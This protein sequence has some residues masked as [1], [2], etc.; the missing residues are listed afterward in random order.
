M[1]GKWFSGCGTVA[2]IKATYRILAKR[3]HPDCGGD[4]ATMAEINGEYEDTLKSADGEVYRDDQD[5]EHTYHYNAKV[6][7]DL[8]NK[9]AELLKLSMADVQ[10]LL[11]GT[12]IWVKGDT[13]PYKDALKSLGLWWNSKRIAWSYHV[14]QWHGHYSDASLNSLAHTYGV[15][16]FEANETSMASA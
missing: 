12:W 1:A 6:E 4:N 11:I 5:N 14:G 13:K 10:V 3:W 7:R 15:R 16:E 9:I 8:M 2:K